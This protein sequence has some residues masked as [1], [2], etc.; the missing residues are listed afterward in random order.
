LE[1][2]VWQSSRV[3]AKFLQLASIPHSFSS[4]S[5]GIH[6]PFW[7]L[8][9]GLEN[10]SEWGDGINPMMTSLVQFGGE[11]SLSRMMA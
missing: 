8:Y 9:Q 2:F 1:V 7:D 11:N 10:G 6:R 5:L 4:F 3:T